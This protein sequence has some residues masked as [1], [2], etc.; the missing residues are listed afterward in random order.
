M[1][2][3]LAFGEQPPLGGRPVGLVEPHRVA[4]RRVGAADVERQAGGGRHGVAGPEGIASKM[5]V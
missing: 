1:N 5:L 2:G 3:L 4:L